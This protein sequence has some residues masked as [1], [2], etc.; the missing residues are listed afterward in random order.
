M[1]IEIR[2]TCEFFMYSEMTVKTEKTELDN[3]SKIDVK[4]FI[5]CANLIKTYVTTNKKHATSDYQQFFLLLQIPKK[6]IEDV[7]QKTC[8]NYFLDC[9]V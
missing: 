9:I 2:Q 4:S 7:L 1:H 5:F 3:F 6:E 8:S